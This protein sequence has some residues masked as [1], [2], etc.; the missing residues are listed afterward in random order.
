MKK[1]MVLKMRIIGRK[2]ISLLLGLVGVGVVCVKKREM[3]LESGV[4]FVIVCYGF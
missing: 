2:F 3:E 4:I 1:Y